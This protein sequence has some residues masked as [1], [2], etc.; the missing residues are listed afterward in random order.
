M[1]TIYSVVKNIVETN[2]EKLPSDVVEVTKRLI[3]DT[4]AV[5]LCGSRETGVSEVVDIFKSWGG[6]KESTVWITG[7]KLPCINAAQINAVM[8]HASD[9]DDTHDPSPVHTGVVALPTAFA[10]A[11]TIGGIDGKKIITAVA[12]ATDFTVRLCIACKISM[13][14]SGWHFTTL[15]GNFNAAA[16]AGKLLGFDEETLVN[17]FGLA[18]H[19]AGGNIQCVHDGVLAKRIGP[20]F[21][22]RNG[23]M[24]ALM[25]QKGITGAK[26]VLD[27]RHGLFNIYHRG[28]YNSEV[29]SAGLGERYEMT[30]IS[31]KPYPCCRNDHPSI[32]AT[33]AIIREN[34]FK[35]EDV[36]AITISLG[37]GA[38]GLLCE[39]SDVKRNPR[40]IVD[41]QF[42][43]PWTVAV[44]IVHGKVGVDGFTEQAIKDKRIL[45]L[46]NKVVPKVDEAFSKRGVTPVIVEIKTKN[47]KVYSKRVD[48]P[49]GS[50][51]NPMD[52]DAIAEKFRDC[53]SNAIK[54]V[55]KDKMEKLIQLIY[56]LETVRDVKQVIRLLDWSK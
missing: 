14:D 40:T 32:D 25:A 49:Y 43:I 34:K 56:N 22:V 23:I 54:P 3:L 5:S 39:P 21:A 36:D 35:P 29:L 26:N 44:A 16:V 17:A 38:M 42:S 28:E 2:Y 33:L 19:Q 55:K 10:I 45:A 27:G 8:I 48:Y 11:E 52:M 1:D 37:S 47:G 6:K 53:A 4:L 50:P 9:Y 15:H 12:L 31:F 41:A 7:D 46:S 30:G 13:F 24:A 20:S 18:Y 51:E